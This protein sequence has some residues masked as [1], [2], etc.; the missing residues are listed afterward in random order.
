MARE[1]KVDSA[2]EPKRSS[3]HA[4]NIA[5][6]VTDVVS[7]SCGVSGA[8]LRETRLDFSD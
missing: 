7:N 4:C 2:N 1:A 6:V 3:A 8:V 5:Y